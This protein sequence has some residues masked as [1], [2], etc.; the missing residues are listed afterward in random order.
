M[1]KQWDRWDIM[2]AVYAKGSNLTAIANSCE[3]DSSSCLHA[4]DRPL[5]AGE[6]AIA[7]FIE[8]DPSIL[9]P[10]RWRTPLTNARS[11]ALEEWRASQI[12][13]LKRSA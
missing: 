2:R 13:K 4:L 1:P 7:S 3:I 6:I 8:V 5:L 11:I 9:W 12:L 10:A